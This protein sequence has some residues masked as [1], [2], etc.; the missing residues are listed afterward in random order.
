MDVRVE[1]PLFIPSDYTVAPVVGA[2]EGED[3][4][5]HVGPAIHVV[6]GQVD[7]SRVA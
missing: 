2:F 7:L 4:R 1:Y 6:L 5:C 3:G